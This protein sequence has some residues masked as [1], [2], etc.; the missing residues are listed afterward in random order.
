M[1]LTANERRLKSSIYF[2]KCMDDLPLLIRTTRECFFVY[3]PPD[4]VS[5]LLM[6][7]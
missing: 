5:E 6:D 4:G 1:H 7:L 2:L 3:A